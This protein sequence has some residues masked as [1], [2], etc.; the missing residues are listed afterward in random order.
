MWF[1]KVW[2]KRRFYQSASSRLTGLTFKIMSIPKTVRASIPRFY[3]QIL[4]S[5]LICFQKF[6][7][8]QKC[9]FGTANLFYFDY[10]HISAHSFIRD[11][12]HHK[13]VSWGEEVY[14]ALPSQIYPSYFRDYMAIFVKNIKAFPN[15]IKN[16][17]I[18]FIENFSFPPKIQV[19]EH[20]KKRNLAKWYDYSWKF[21]RFH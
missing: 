10:F 18:F 8:S 5:K 1:D 3:P 11:R 21:L 15:A 6:A 12:K 17:V 19:I 13:T 4:V 2:L 7:H 14:G 9:L 20:V 16:L